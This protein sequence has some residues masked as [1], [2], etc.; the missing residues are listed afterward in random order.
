MLPAVQTGV[1]H[2]R[3]LVGAALLLAVFL[4]PFQDGYQLKSIIV[5]IIKVI[6]SRKANMVGQPASI[7]SLCLLSYLLSVQGLPLRAML[8]DDSHRVFFS[9]DH[10]EVHL[11]LYHPRTEAG[12][13]RLADRELRIIT[14]GQDGHADHEFHLSDYNQ[15]MLPTGKTLIAKNLVP[16]EPV[17]FPVS[18][19]IEPVA[20]GYQSRPPPGKS[21]RL[22]LLRVTVLLI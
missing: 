11:V 20:V 6:F 4:L 14:T 3:R 7:A 2:T 18:K 15:R 10:S 21:L 19:L 12:H 13:R 16:P 8:A 5:S 22:A 1:F 17:N 9:Y